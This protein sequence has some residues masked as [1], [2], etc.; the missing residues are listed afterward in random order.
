MYQYKV[1]FDHQWCCILQICRLSFQASAPLDAISQFRKHVDLFKEKVGAAELAFEH[2]AWLSKQW[3][4]ELCFNISFARYMLKIDSATA[5][6]HYNYKPNTV[7]FPNNPWK[8]K[9]TLLFIQN[10]HTIFGYMRW[11]AHVDTLACFPFLF[12]ASSFLSV[13][14]FGWTK[15]YSFLTE[16]NVCFA[17]RIYTYVDPSDGSKFIHLPLKLTTNKNNK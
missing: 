17:T 15:D 4:F 8:D 3:V 5:C 1:V 11:H 9:S 13:S 10:A 2:S 16:K 6:I 7:S 14:L 12:M